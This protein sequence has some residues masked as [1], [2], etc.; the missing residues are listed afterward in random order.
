MDHI[1]ELIDWVVE[2]SNDQIFSL[3]KYFTEQLESI[4]NDN[5]VNKLKNLSKPKNQQRLSTHSRRTI[6]AAIS[7]NCVTTTTSTGTTIKQQRRHKLQQ[8][9]TTLTKQTVTCRECNF[10][11]RYPHKDDI[12]WCVKCQA[13]TFHKL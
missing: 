9:S 11:R 5:N 7:P 3:S 8:S 12:Q 13:I 4:E 6:S 10:S 2:L 1:Y